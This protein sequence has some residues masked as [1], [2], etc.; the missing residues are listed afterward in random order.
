MTLFWWMIFMWVIGI[1]TGMCIGNPGHR[2]YRPLYQRYQRLWYEQLRSARPHR[3]EV[4]DSE[5]CDCIGEC[6]IPEHQWAEQ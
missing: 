5:V 1:L 2:H 3:R 4:Y 6:V